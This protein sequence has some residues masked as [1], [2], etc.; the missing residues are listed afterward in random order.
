MEASDSIFKE[1]KEVRD[2]LAAL[3]EHVD[4]PTFT[5]KRGRNTEQENDSP[6]AE[7]PKRQHQ[8]ERDLDTLERAGYELVP[9]VIEN[10]HGTFE[11]W[12]KVCVVGGISVVTGLC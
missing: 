7:G 8:R 6:D 12:C 5:S 4:G 2:A 10:D 11:P 1:S 9:D 3:K